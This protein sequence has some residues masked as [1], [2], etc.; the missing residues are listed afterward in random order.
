MIIK[1][2]ANFLE[3]FGGANAGNI[4]K[5]E[6]EYYIVT[7]DIDSE[8]NCVKLTTGEGKWIHPTEK[9]QIYRE[10]ELIIKG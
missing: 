1:D 10:V 9:V 7:E 5:F 3:D 4:I 6:G 2:N 8:T